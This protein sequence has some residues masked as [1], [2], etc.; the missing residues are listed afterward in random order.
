MSDITKNDCQGEDAEPRGDLL[1]RA[2]GRNRFLRDRGEIKTP[3][4]IDELAAEISAL[5]E[6][7]NE[8]REIMERINREMFEHG[9]R[10]PCMKA[11]RVF[12]GVNT[13]V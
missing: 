11:L 7:L 12:L 4:L 2:E 1:I 10:L 3:E 9:H 5:K 13:D 6:K 8:A